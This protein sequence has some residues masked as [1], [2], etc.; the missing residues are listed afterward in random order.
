MALLASGIA[1]RAAPSE[2]QQTQRSFDFEGM[3]VGAR[4]TGFSFAL[5]GGGK[6]PDWRVLNEQTA[7]AGSKAL[8]E[9]SRDRTDYRF[10]LAIVDDI[11]ARNVHVDIECCPF[12]GEIDRAAGVVW[13]LRDHNNYYVARA[14]ALENNV[15]LY[16]VVEGRRLQIAGANTTV[17]SGHWQRLAVTASDTSIVVSLNGAVL[18]RASDHTFDTSG[19]VGLWTK[20]DSVTYFDRLVVRTL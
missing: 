12:E 9:L 16:K 8:V 13:R 15:R 11:H 5:T 20:A 4:P 17:R 7:P 14:N 19:R 3:V 1:V 18:L 6:D 10:P 2:A